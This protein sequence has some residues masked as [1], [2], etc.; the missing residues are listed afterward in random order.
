[1]NLRPLPPETL[2]LYK[3]L[4]P[5]ERLILH[6]KL[7]HDVAAVLIEQVVRMFPNLAFDV[8]AVRF[9]AAVHD[10][11]K[12]LHHPQELIGPGRSH[13]RDGP[14]LLESLGVEPRLARFARTHGMWQSE[15]VELE[16]LLVALADTLWKGKRDES[17]EGL[18]VKKIAEQVGQESWAV[19]EKLD[20]I[21]DD[22][23]ADGERR[24]VWQASGN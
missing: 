19:F 10:L 11:G 23:A 7:V 2:R 1:M 12:V 21:A 24:L 18:I 15:P 6:L 3:E 17:L 8:E 13:E 20:K 16:D 14:P 9:G 22:L 4:Q 5:P